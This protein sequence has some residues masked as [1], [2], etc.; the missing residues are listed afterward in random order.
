MVRKTFLLISLLLT[1]VVYGRGQ[2]L[3]PKPVHEQWGGGEFSMPS[4]LRIYYSDIEVQPLAAYLS[5]EL[6]RNHA[7]ESGKPVQALRPLSDRKK[8]VRLVL[9][10][11]M[12]I[13]SEGY[14]LTVAANG[15]TIMA[16]DYGGLF[17]GVQTML[18][19]MPLPGSEGRSVR[20]GNVQD[21]PRF[22]YRGMHLDVARTFSPKEDVMRYIDNFSRHKINKFHWH[23][24]DD[25]GWRIEIKSC[26]EL[27]MEGGFRGG[28]SP[29]EAV[30]GEWGNKYGGYY[31]HEDIREIVRYAAVR[32]VEI[33]PEVDLPGHSRTA[34][35]V[36]PEILCSGPFDT[37]STAGYDRRDVW[38][39]AREE[40][41]AIL[42]DVFREIASLFPSKYIH[43]GG[44]EV[45][46]SQWNGCPRC[47]EL[48]R[49]EGIADGHGLECHFMS[50]LEKILEKY[51]KSAGVWNEAIDGG[52]LRN[53]TMVYGWE[54]VAACVDATNQG[55]PTIVMPGRYFYFDMK[56]TAEEPGMTWA[57]IV[58]TEDVYSFDFATQGMPAK[59]MANV[60]GVEGTF[61][62]EL[63]LYQSNFYDNYLDRQT[64]P[65]ICA[66]AE[67]AWTPQELRDW[68]DF[69]ARM[70]GGHYARLR[71]L[72]IKYRTAPDPA[73]KQVF[74]TP[75]MTVTSSMPEYSRNPFSNI[76]KYKFGTQSRTTRTCREGDY[77][78]FTFAEPVECSS[79]EFVTGYAYLKRCH[80]TF[81]YAEVLYEGAEEWSRYADLTAGE[82]T[83]RPARPVKAVRLVSTVPRNGESTVIF[84][85]VKIV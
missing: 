6:G 28:D 53:T 7:I 22:A 11:G 52:D 82:V 25:E 80:I 8:G 64:Y 31:T 63:Y 66:L 9:D 59:N 23:L 55:Y 81:G 33:I 29:V 34:A 1:G 27:A 30:Y 40:N 76:E 21:Y 77:V 46:M 74:L 73:P 72:G 16:T 65:R 39:A 57:G 13:A 12:A 14:E 84:Q 37:V 50:R 19:L 70:D 26:P 79:M 43:V 62:S 5:E 18:Q 83:I 3:V 61:F 60:A 75:E 56:Y 10:A 15:I 38:C 67:L 71:N 69:S 42:D 47:R 78:Q 54:D 32:N 45:N 58:S 35:N 49:Q 20:Y 4:K 36:Y 17:N 41:Y 51:G 68:D 24:T 48:M 44:D 85:P 2:H